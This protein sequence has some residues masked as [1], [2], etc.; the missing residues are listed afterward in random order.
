MKRG[1]IHIGVPG[2]A[3]FFALALGM[4]I[5]CGGEPQVPEPVRPVKYAEVRTASAV[6]SQRFAGT[7]RAGTE[8][9]LSFRTGGLIESIDA[10]A[11]DRVKAGQRLAALD[12]RDA[13]L[14]YQKARAALENARVQKANAQSGLTRMRQLYQADNVSLAE[15]E[16]AKAGFAAA[17]SSHESAEKSLDLQERQL[18]FN[19]IR[20]PVDGIVTAVNFEVNEVIQAGAPLVELSAGA[21][22]EMEVGVPEGHIARIGNGDP[23][24]VRFSALPGV[25]FAAR[26]REISWALDASSTYPVRVRLDAPSPSIRPGMAGD[27]E[28]RF[29][30]G[31]ADPLVVPVKAVGEDASG[32]YVFVIDGVDQGVGTVQRRAVRVGSLL[33]DGFVVEEGLAEGE[34][35][36]TAGLRS[37][38]KGMKVRLLE[39]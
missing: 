25:E 21:D 23:V 8:A 2:S 15:Y 9:R 16:Q 6:S 20:A 37:L 19:E 33:A 10:K 34:L 28:F 18:R 30:A 5:G 4:W 14:A 22:I 36:A 7:A 38:M 31:G 17:S 12:S 27:A 32:R 3:G 11:G 13:A 35:V 26:V 29:G 39:E 24:S 1:R